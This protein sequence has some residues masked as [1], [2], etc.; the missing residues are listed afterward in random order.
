MKKIALLLLSFISVYNSF[1]QCSVNTLNISTGYNPIAGALVTPVVVDPK[2][3]SRVSNAAA[4]AITADGL[5]AGCYDISPYPLW[6]A[7]G[8]ACNWISS[9]D[10]FGYHT[11]G[12]GIDVYTMTLSRKFSVC[13]PD[14]LSLSMNIQSEDGI[15]NILFDGVP[16]YTHAF[17][18][19]VT[20][21]TSYNYN[22]GMVAM[23][24]HTISVEVHN[25]NDGTYDNPIGMSM[26]GS[27]ASVG[28]ASS[29]VNEG[30]IACAPVVTVK[31]TA[32]C[33]ATTVV[34]QTT[35]PGNTY[36]WNTG[37]TTASITTGTVGTYFVNYTTNAC[38]LRTDTFHVTSRV[39]T[40]TIASHNVVACVGPTVLHATPG[41]TA[42]HW[43]TG[44]SDSTLSVSTSGT[45]YVVASNCVTA[46]VDT[47]HVTISSPLTVN[48]GPDGDLCVG[49]VLALSS[50]QPAG[51][52]YQ[53]SNGST[54]TTINVITTGT[55]WLTVYN[56]CTASDTIRITLRSVPTV[57]LANDTSFC[58]GNSIVLSS[59][60]PAG[61]TYTWSTGSTAA[62]ITA[63]TTG[64]YWLRV[65]NGTCSATDTMH[66]YV[67]PFPT[68]VNLGPDVADCD[69]NA[70]TLQS[71]VAYSTPTYLWNNGSTG[72]T[73]TVT[74]TG[75]YWL[76]VRE[77]G[78]PGTDTI[79][80]QISYD[81]LHVFN[82][83]TAVCKGKSVKIR[84]DAN[85]TATY[86]WLPTT[87]IAH[88]DVIAPIIIADTSAMYYLNVFMDGCPTRRDSVFIDVQPM[89]TVVLSGNKFVCP[90]DTVHLTAEV[91]P[92][93][94]G[95]YIY[96]WTPSLFLDHSDTRT[97][98]YTPG[99]TQEYI[100]T[101]STTAGCVGSD[102]SIVTVYPTSF[103]LVGN[104]DIC[105]RD[106]ALLTAGGGVAYSWYPAVS[107]SSTTSAVPWAKPVAFTTYNVAITSADGCI[108][109]LSVDVNVWP[110]GMIYAGD[111]ISLFPGETYHVMPQTN[112]S[113]FIWFPS[114]GVSNVYQ[115]DPILAPL[116]DTRYVVYGATEH[117]CKAEDSLSVYVNAETA[118]EMPNAF[119]P[120]NSSGGNSKAYVLRRGEAT[121]N[122][123][124]IY[125]RWGNMVF[126]T[127]NIAEGWD[128]KYKDEP[129]AFGV[130]VYEIQAVSNS[131][132]LFT[133]RGNITLLR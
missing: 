29:I 85:P 130:Y 121:L 114:E 68:V 69:G 52:T 26:Y 131:G 10:H 90:K 30:S 108:D 8:P 117:G 48:L 67:D 129:Q 51:T 80:V 70:V 22:L 31:D 123:Y 105:P 73:L 72:P 97:V 41:L 49:S 32:I 37:A 128:G 84:A 5:T 15:T 25:C 35:G 115:S 45:Y 125:N 27:I 34:L 103:S 89:P 96:N 120:D 99:T 28:G 38:M 53:W 110:G 116:A 111:S 59:P 14:I 1:A 94:Y 65:S 98:V 60:Q 11:D 77:I 21:Y 82:P 87:G 44:S 50:P 33:P 6:P 92:S 76:K 101:V 93:W 71:S 18:C 133:K 102:S 106:S 126:E 88:S 55:Y 78:C 57:T 79:H 13:T 100:L 81:T 119:T 54:A 40:T 43:N 19:G 23:G 46:S 39:A 16:L 66:I 112:C 62:T 61:Y 12:S 127:K 109:T 83:D 118:L 3:T 17:A 86:Q 20:P 24:T 124:R 58:S 47:Y 74:T 95:G 91:S 113:S 56:G 75:T 122:Y 107:L 2:W 64:A 63:S 42:Y 104:Q 36:L 7:S 132:K 9:Q 4:A